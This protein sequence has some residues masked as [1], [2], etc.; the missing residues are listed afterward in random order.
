MPEPD[1]ETREQ[2]DS[3][4]RGCFVHIIQRV[5]TARNSLETKCL[6]A[7]GLKAKDRLLSRQLGNAA[8]RA[9]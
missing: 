2:A 8:I 9:F 1:T 3:L 5:M 6:A 4:E 7:E